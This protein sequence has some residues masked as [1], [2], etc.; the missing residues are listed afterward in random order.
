MPLKHSEQSSTHCQ[1]IT[2]SGQPC[3][4]K[5]RQ[6]GLC[7]FHG[8]PLR[9]VELGRKGGRRKTTF[10][11]DLKEIAAPKSAGDIRD[12]L[13]QS[14]IEIR[15]GKLDPRRANSISY[16]GAGFLRALEVSDLEARLQA[17]EAKTQE[18]DAKPQTQT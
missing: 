13:A 16:L 17:L 4:A 3:K 6:D 10:A 1:A 2:S 12:L 5:P 8:D 7:F 11:G 14:I 15:E 9:A 18:I